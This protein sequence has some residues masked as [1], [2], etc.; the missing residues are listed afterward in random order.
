MT[1]F[2]VNDDFL[3]IEP[4]QGEYVN[5][6]GQKHYSLYIITRGKETIW[7]P[8]QLDMAYLYL[9]RL[10]YKER[11][12][13]RNCLCCQKPFMSEGAHNRMCKKCRYAETT[14]EDIAI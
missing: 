12:S 8:G 9:D 13:K 3:R 14:A 6:S 10:R 1:G 4:F 11:L 5:R 7:G 2:E